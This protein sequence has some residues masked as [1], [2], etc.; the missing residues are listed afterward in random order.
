MS[1]NT[2]EKE[3]EALKSHLGTRESYTQDQL[4]IVISPFRVS[5]LGHDLELEGGPALAMT[6]D[7]YAV[8]AFIPSEERKVRLYNLNEPGVTE[9]D[10]AVVKA[11]EKGDWGRYVMGAARTFGERYSRE[12]G[13]TGTVHRTLTGSGL[14][15]ATSECLSYLKALSHANGVDP[16]VWEYAEFTSRIKNEYLRETVGNLDQLATLNGR[17]NFLLHVLT[18]PGDVSALPG[19]EYGKDY[20]IVIAYSGEN[21]QRTRD[22]IESRLT[23]CKEVSGYLGIMAGITSGDR[24]SDIPAEVYHS[25]SKRLPPLLKK[26]A[27]HYF[28]EAER[29]QKGL[30]SWRKGDLETLGRQMKESCAASLEIDKEAGVGTVMLHRVISSSEGVY[31]SNINGEY[32]IA[33]VRPDFSEQLLTQ[34]LDKYLRVCPEAEG[35]AFGFIT[36]QEESLRIE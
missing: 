36:E 19:P 6:V 34:A 25:N 11:A 2:L 4:K 3:I 14:G 1:S 24:L 5:L 33:L 21:E 17:K 15:Q 8:L 30:D 22:E 35:K 27:G 9:F 7:A 12:K 26:R 31:G 28:G 23:E 18:G 13:F 32:V 16:L 20:R 10:P 29:V